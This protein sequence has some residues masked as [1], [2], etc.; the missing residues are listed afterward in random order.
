MLLTK[1]RAAVSGANKAYLLCPVA[2]SYTH[3]TRVTK[4]NNY[5]GDAWRQIAVHQGGSLHAAGFRGKGMQIAVIDAGFYNA[6]EISVCLLYT[7]NAYNLW[8]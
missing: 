8:E 2:V 7:S 3:L 6:D 4:R 1:S 5:Y